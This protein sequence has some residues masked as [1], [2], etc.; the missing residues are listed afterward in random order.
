MAA[1][2]LPVDIV[3]HIDSVGQLLRHKMFH[4]WPPIEGPRLRKFQVKASAIAN[5]VPGWELIIWAQTA[6]NML[7]PLMLHCIREDFFH[8]KDRKGQDAGYRN[9]IA[10]ADDPLLV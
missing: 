10:P 5:S 4:Y 9:A 6:R 7:S 1:P 2:Q 8:V 3:P